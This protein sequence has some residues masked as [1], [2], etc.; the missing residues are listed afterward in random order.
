MCDCYNIFIY[1]TN[2]DI[3]LYYAIIDITRVY[4]LYKKLNREINYYC[5]ESINLLKY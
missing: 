4:Y 3:V 2:Y 5:F 1:P